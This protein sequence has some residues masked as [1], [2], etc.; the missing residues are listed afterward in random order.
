MSKLG[1]TV[2]L[3]DPKGNRVI[4]GPEDKIPSWAEAA[5]PNPDAWEI[6]P[7]RRGS[8]PAPTGEPEIPDDASGDDAESLDSDLEADSDTADEDEEPTALA[9]PSEETEETEAAPD[10]AS[11]TPKANASRAAWAAYAAEAT[12]AA[13]LQV[14][15]ADDA[16]RAD[17]IAALKQA[18][19]L[20]E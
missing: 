18:G 4:L 2:I 5:I 14:A 9:E 13:G 8:T 7:K 6:A 16:S 17:I 15:I 19:I 20:K 11:G 12:A 1:K 10:A 3:R